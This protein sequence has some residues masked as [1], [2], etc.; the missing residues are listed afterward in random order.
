MKAKR[1]PK[2]VSP[3]RDMKALCKSGM[4]CS[5]CGS[6]IASS[7]ARVAMKDDELVYICLR[8]DEK[9][10]PFLNAPRQEEE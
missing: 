2:A 7:F 5:V 10:T 8:C 6:T 3:R 9:I 1:S 4:V